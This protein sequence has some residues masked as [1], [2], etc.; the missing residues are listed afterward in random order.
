M[1]SPVLIAEDFWIETNFNATDTVRLA[2]EIVDFSG[3]ETGSIEITYIK[4]QHLIA[5]TESSKEANT[6]DKNVSS[7]DAEFDNLLDK[8]GEDNL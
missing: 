8:W 5:P 4:Q 6:E 1:I 7:G 3:V 2:A